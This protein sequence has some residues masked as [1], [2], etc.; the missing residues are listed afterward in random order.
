M[1]RPNLRYLDI[2]R[3]ETLAFMNKNIKS[4]YFDGSEKVD[5]DVSLGEAEV[6]FSASDEV[7]NLSESG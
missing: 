3:A 5:L 6:L 2:I 7:K 4:N 1:S